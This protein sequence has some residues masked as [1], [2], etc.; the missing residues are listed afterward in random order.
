MIYNM[1]AKGKSGGGG[2]TVEVEPNDVTFIDYDGTVLYSYTAQEFLALNAMPANPSHDGLISQGW[3]WTL[4]DAK[5]QVQ[6]VGE[7]IIGQMYITDDGKTRLYCRF[8]DGRLSP[9]LG[10]GVN[11]TVVI[12]WGDGSATD[13]L[14]GT[15]LSTAQQVLHTYNKAGRYTI[16]LTATNGEYAIFGSSSSYLIRKQNGSSDYFYSTSNALKAVRIGENCVLKNY[17]FGYCMALESITIPQGVTMDG[18]HLFYY[19][20]NLRAVVVPSGVPAF[21]NY[22][23]DYTNVE[24]VS[25]P[26]YDITRGYLFQMSKLLRLIAL[27]YK[28]TAIGTTAFNGT[29]GLAHIVIPKNVTSIGTNAF[30]LTRGLGYFKILRNT[31]PSITNANVLSGIPADCTIYVPKG[32]LSAYQSATNWSNFADQMVE[33]D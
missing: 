16:T 6:E 30:G 17:A 22:M 5:T 24:V 28:I 25:L 23:F 3:N 11:G 21:A 4:A 29:H 20:E 2:G 32:S 12:D 31:P 1:V 15:S 9:Y 8:E 13:T 33:M 10:L 27:P 14:T 18:T 19:S 26:C 7:A